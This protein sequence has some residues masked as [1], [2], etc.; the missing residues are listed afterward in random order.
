MKKLYVIAHELSP[1]LGSECGS[2]W[3]IVNELSQYYEVNVFHSKKN[4]MG[5]ENYHDHIIS[6]QKYNFKNINFI[7]VDYPKF[8]KYLSLFSKFTAPSKSVTGNQFLYF[9]IYNI[10]L[11]KVVNKINNLNDVNGVYY[12]NHISYLSISPLSKLRVP[13]IIGPISGFTKVPDSMIHGENLYFRLKN[14]IRNITITYKFNFSKKFL[15]TIKSASHVFCVSKSELELVS[16]INTSASQLIDVGC[17]NLHKKLRSTS[18]KLMLLSVGRI[19]EYKA[20]HLLIKALSEIPFVNEKIHLDVLGDGVCKDKI[21]KLSLGLGL[22]CITFHGRVDRENVFSFMRRSDLLVHTSIKE[23][24]CSVVLEALSC[25][26]PVIVHDEFG[27]SYSIDDNVG[28]KIPYKNQDCSILCLKAILISLIDD[29]SLLSV[30]SD[31]CISRV[32]ELSWNNL[33][34]EINRFLAKYF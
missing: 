13:Y 31:S 9:F 30:K 25:Q 14:L 15:N 8:A 1:K 3:K 17:E 20:L 34:K 29:I 22:N 7:A 10:W 12:L 11:K 18:Q 19:D 4:Q 2:A 33:V 27:M 21:Q 23:A 5:T 32:H 28:F 6:F 26:L 24:G 16:L